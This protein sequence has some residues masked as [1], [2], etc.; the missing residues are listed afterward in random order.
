MKRAGTK[1]R[2]FVLTLVTFGDVIMLT[3]SNARITTTAPSSNTLLRSLPAAEYERLAV[4]LKPVPVSARQY[5]QR[6]DTPIE[7]VY[8]PNEG[9]VC[10]V[11]RTMDGGATVQVAAVGSEG[12]LGI[13]VV[14]GDV[15]SSNDLQ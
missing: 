1:R 3:G 8:F 2:R 10:S 15:R 5:L 11:V 4:H 6:H 14:Y 9:S 12:F 13:S 7:H